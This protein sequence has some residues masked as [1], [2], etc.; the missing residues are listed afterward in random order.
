MRVGQVARRAGLSPRAVRFYEA[1][2][3]LPLAERTASGYRQYAE[4]EVEQLRL[5]AQ[6]RRVGLSLADVREII[7]LRQL[8]VPPAD[9]VISLLEAR[10][11]RLDRDLDSLHEAR[12]RLV[13]VLHRTRFAVSGGG[14]VRLCRLVGATSANGIPTAEPLAEV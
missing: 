2:G 6:L 9:R 11:A 3:L 13:E 14:D 1:E 12:C 10:I 5:I 8:G 4:H 7:R